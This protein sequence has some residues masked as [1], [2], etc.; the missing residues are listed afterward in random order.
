[1]TVPMFRIF[2]RYSSK[3]RIH[4]FKD[5]TP[6]QIIIWW[7]S[8]SLLYSEVLLAKQ[9]QDLLLKTQ[10]L[11]YAVAC[12][13][14]YPSPVPLPTASSLIVPTPGI[15]FFEHTYLS[16]F[17]CTTSHHTMQLGLIFEPM[18]ASSPPPPPTTYRFIPPVLPFA[19]LPSPSAVAQATVAMAPAVRLS[20][21]SGWNTYPGHTANGE[22]I[23][24]VAAVAGPVRGRK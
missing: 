19:L 23:V 21:L 6:N 4:T 15:S 1:M 3:T 8:W 24:G 11:I 9:F 14:A 2:K 10:F 20:P 17:S 12:D 7:V 22:F 18:S 5:R 16:L 13:S